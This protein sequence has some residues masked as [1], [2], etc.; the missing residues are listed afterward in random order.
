MAWQGQPAVQP[1][2]ATT[3]YAMPAQKV[4]PS[5]AVAPPLPAG[6]PPPLPAA[7]T[8]AAAAN[9]YAAYNAYP[10]TPEQQY[11]MQW[12]AYQ[13]QYAQWQA[14]Y[15]EQVSAINCIYS[16]AGR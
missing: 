14:M 16:P 10:M 12:Q 9:P 3:N 7:D 1:P 6:P 15:G 13:Q 8:T 11:Y 4:A 5:T 2:V